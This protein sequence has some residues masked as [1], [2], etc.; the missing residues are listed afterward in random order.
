MDSRKRPSHLSPLLDHYKRE[1]RSSAQSSETSVSS[2]DVLVKHRCRL[3]KNQ[4]FKTTEDFDIHLSM[5]HFRDRLLDILGHP[6]YTC[7]YCGYQPSSDDPNEDMIVHYGT[8]EKMALKFYSEECKKLPPIPCKLC[9]KSYENEYRLLI[10]ITERHV[11]HQL[12]QKLPQKSPYK[13]PIQNCFEEKGDKNELMLHYGLDHGQTMDLY[14]KCLSKN[15]ESKVKTSLNDSKSN[16]D[17]EKSSKKELKEVDMFGLTPKP[18]KEFNSAKTPSTMIS[19]QFCMEKK[20]NIS[21]VTKKSLNYHLILNHFFTSILSKTPVTCPKC[22]TNFPAKNEF[23][24]HFIEKH[25]DKFMENKEYNKIKKKEQQPSLKKEKV[26]TTSLE[27]LLKDEM[28]VK[29]VKPKDEEAPL[30]KSREMKTVHGRPPREMNTLHGPP[31]EMKTMH[32]PKQIP[33][34]HEIKS[35]NTPGSGKCHFQAHF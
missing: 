14:S 24:K 8:Q 1:R 31:R 20:K 33:S 26:T 11:S 2:E 18:K 22:S 19:C 35:P 15:S 21:F 17:I 5:I 34:S 23:A 25:F 3:C 7:R 9:S 29:T 4:A 32:K 10:H 13:C 16:N 28:K 12:K 30:P 27:N 6:P